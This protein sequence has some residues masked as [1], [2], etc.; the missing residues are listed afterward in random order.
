MFLT[1]E[2]SLSGKRYNAL[3]VVYA[4][5][6]GSAFRLFSRDYDFNSLIESALDDLQNE[7]AKLGA[8]GFIG[9]CHTTSIGGKEGDWMI[10]TAMGTAIKFY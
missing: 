9:I 1:T 7:A 10:V 3:R 6:I 4:T 2:P 8:D 5:E